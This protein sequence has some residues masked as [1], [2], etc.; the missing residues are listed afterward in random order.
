MMMCLCGL[1]VRVAV[2]RG[3]VIWCHSD[4]TRRQELARMLREH[5][6]DQDPASLL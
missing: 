3:D 2:S 5:A 1:G 4:R 6:A